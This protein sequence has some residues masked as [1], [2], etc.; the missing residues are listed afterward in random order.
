MLPQ[1][2]SNN[3]SGLAK[4][5]LIKSPKIL[6]VSRGDRVTL[7]SLTKD[8]GSPHPLCPLAALSKYVNMLANRNFCTPLPNS[9]HASMASNK[10]GSAPSLSCHTKAKMVSKNKFESSPQDELSTSC[11]K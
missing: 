7:Y 3:L 1:T 9:S 5:S 10:P 11:R 8:D 6:R 2:V 4:W